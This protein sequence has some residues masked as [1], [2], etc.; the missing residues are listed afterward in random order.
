MATTDVNVV[1]I[2]HDEHVLKT[3]QLI[4]FHTY[5]L[6]LGYKDRANLIPRPRLHQKE[7]AMLTG[8]SQ[9]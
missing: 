4:L 7:Q 5:S 3:H 9:A 1:V 8:T 6:S 2:V